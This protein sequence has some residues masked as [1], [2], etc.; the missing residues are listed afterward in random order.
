MA[1]IAAAEQRFTYATAGPDPYFW[2]ADAS[3]TDK[4][5]S[6]KKKRPSDSFNFRSNELRSGL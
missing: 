1:W 6:P 5:G 2:S 3:K 4:G